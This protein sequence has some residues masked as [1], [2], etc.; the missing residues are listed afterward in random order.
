MEL[1]FEI[2][3]D[4]STGDFYEYCGINPFIVDNGELTI[5]H[6]EPWSGNKVRLVANFTVEDDDLW[7][8]EPIEV[9]FTYCDSDGNTICVIYQIDQINC[10]PNPIECNIWNTDIE[11]GYDSKQNDYVVNVTYCMSLY[12][13]ADSGCD[14]TEYNLDATLSTQ[15]GSTTSIYNETIYNPNNETIVQ[16]CVTVQAPLDVYLQGNSVV[17]F[18][19]E[20]NCPDIGCFHSFYNFNQ[21]NS[22][23]S[24]R[25]VKPT[26]NEVLASGDFKYDITLAYEVDNTETDGM[27]YMDGQVIPLNKNALGFYNSIEVTPFSQSTV[28]ASGILSYISVNGDNRASYFEYS[29]DN[30][31][32]QTR[33]SDESI[34]DIKAFPNPFSDKISI[35]SNDFHSLVNSDIK[36]FNSVGYE[37]EFNS[38]INEFSIDVSINDQPGIYII[39]I[40]GE[41]GKIENLK[42]I[43]I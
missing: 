40:I 35:M 1:Y 37:V 6:I 15:G 24:P 33:S 36:I 2:P 5:Q 28:N 34:F 19:L 29:L 3:V 41:N 4:Q 22:S 10:P 30:C 23:S 7:S 18:D 31:F 25:I 39:Q 27:L 13:I 26:C 32:S 9:Q 12:F 20:T 42:L 11:I 43:K 14:V 8:A 17:G 38:V 21:H 16:H